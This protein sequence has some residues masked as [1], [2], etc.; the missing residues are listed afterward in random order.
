MDVLKS[1]GVGE[2]WLLI[3]AL[4]AALVKAMVK[5]APKFGV[6]SQSEKAKRKLDEA[7]SLISYIVAV[8]ALVVGILL[9]AS[10]PGGLLPAIIGLLIL[11]GVFF[12][13]RHFGKVAKKDLQENPPPAAPQDPAAPQ[14]QE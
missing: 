13:L 11:V 5:A 14:P 10:N 9:L 1:L 3:A 2:T 4:T 6:I 8:A 7:D 12:V